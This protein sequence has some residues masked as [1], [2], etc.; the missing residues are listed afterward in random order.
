MRIVAFL[1][2][3]CA[4]GAAFAEDPAPGF[5]PYRFGMTPEEARAAAPGEW[6][7]LERTSPDYV[8]A[9]APHMQIG[10]TLF[11][12]ALR[13]EGHRL[14][15]FSFKSPYAAES[16]ARCVE[17]MVHVLEHYEGEGIVFAGPRTIIEPHGNAL[18]TTTRGGSVVRRYSGDD[19]VVRWIASRYDNAFAQIEAR[20]GE[21]VDS[22]S[23]EILCDV[24]ISVHPYTVFTETELRSSEPTQAELDAADLIEASVWIERPGRRAFMRHYPPGANAVG[25]EGTVALDCLVG[26]DGRLRCRVEEEEP[27]AQGF[28]LAALAMAR[29]FRMAPVLPDGAPTEGGRVRVSLRFRI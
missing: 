25:I 13:F 28:G 11:R 6:R 12:P 24:R 7:E 5:G 3:L 4:A 14:T 20:R 1:F 2:A 26:A 16:E 22:Q 21:L 29:D 8:D 18:E 15:G 19:G 23:T 17:I 10:G 9:F 27:M